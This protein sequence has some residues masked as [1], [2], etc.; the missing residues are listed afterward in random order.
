MRKFYNADNEFK[1]DALTVFSGW[2][3]NKKLPKPKP[4]KD[5]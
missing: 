2:G 5:T 1:Y 3:E 4:M